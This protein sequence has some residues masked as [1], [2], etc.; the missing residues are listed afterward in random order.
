MSAATALK[1]MPAVTYCETTRKV[2][3]GWFRARF[4]DGTWSAL[5]ASE[6]SLLE[7]FASYGFTTTRDDSLQPPPFNPITEIAGLDPEEEVL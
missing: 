2:T 7:Y 3:S 4:K 1:P 5:F 6:R